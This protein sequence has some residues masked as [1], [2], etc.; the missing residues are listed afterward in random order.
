MEG[1]QRMGGRDML[2]QIIEK[3]IVLQHFAIHLNL[4]ISALSTL[5]KDYKDV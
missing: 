1:C 4:N 3:R 2:L 5:N